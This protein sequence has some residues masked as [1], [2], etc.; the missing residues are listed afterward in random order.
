MIRLIVFRPDLTETVDW[1][2]RIN[3]LHIS[4]ESLR[5]HKSFLIFDN[6]DDWA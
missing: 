1:A 2:L 5:V 3:D 6:V 4:L